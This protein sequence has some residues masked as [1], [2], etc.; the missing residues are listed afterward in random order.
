MG[1]QGVIRHYLRLAP[2]VSTQPVSDVTTASLL[3]LFRTGGEL[4]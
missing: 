3:A 1:A 2:S 4:T